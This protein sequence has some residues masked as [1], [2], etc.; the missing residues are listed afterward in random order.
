MNSGIDRR[1][2]SKSKQV[3][4]YEEV[5]LDMQLAFEETY[6]QTVTRIFPNR[7]RSSSS[8]GGSWTSRRSC[9]MMSSKR[10]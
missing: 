10:Y 8:T 7:K 3:V 2:M 6:Q 1:K 5:I 4:M 9:P